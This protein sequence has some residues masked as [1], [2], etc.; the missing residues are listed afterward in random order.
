MNEA[1]HY[2]LVKH[3]ILTA[4][5]GPYW[6]SS[7]HPPMFL[8]VGSN[9]GGFSLYAT[10]VDPK[11]VALA[12]EPQSSL[13]RLIV[14]ASRINGVADRLRVLNCA[15]HE[16]S[17][18]KVGMKDTIHDGGIGSI[19]TDFASADPSNDFVSTLRI[20]ELIAKEDRI[21][22]MKVDVESYEVIAL[23]SARSMLSQ[24]SN[25]LVEWGPASR[26]INESRTTVEEGSS[27]LMSLMDD[28]GFS[29]KLL[30]SLCFYGFD[31]AIFPETWLE[32]PVTMA[33]TMYRPVTKET[34]PRFVDQFVRTDKEC[35]LWLHR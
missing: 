12:V 29:I 28:E 27:L 16:V 30:N 21:L 10:Q 13:A 15:V 22:I 23:R 34:F 32:S 19:T 33:P 6:A 8:D 20:E 17:G 18:M 1:E 26:W 3:L 4:A 25:I 11:L 7:D 24:V 35:Y 31:S 2:N 5:S 14:L 9:H